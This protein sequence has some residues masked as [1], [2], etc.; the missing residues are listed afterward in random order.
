MGTENHISQHAI[1]CKDCQS[2]IYF[3]TK[4]K[5][6]DFKCA[7]CGNMVH[8]PVLEPEFRYR[9]SSLV[10]DPILQ[11][12]YDAKTLPRYRTKIALLP[13][14]KNVPLAPAPKTKVPTH[15]AQ[16]KK[17]TSFTPTKTSKQIKT[18]TNISQSKYDIKKPSAI[19]NTVYF[20][21]SRLKDD[22][23]LQDLFLRYP[24]L[25]K[26]F[27]DDPSNLDAAKRI[28]KSAFPERMPVNYVLARYELPGNGES[29]R[30]NITIRTTLSLYLKP[31]IDPNCQMSLS[32]FVGTK[33][34]FCVTGIDVVPDNGNT[35]EEKQVRALADAL[36][37][38]L[39]G[40]EAE[41]ARLAGRS[42]A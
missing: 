17:R 31:R 33:S 16:P 24:K 41:L 13:R 39:E 28:I 7:V 42:S 3:I 14:V 4:K 40:Y 11:Y 22:D 6:L 9:G 26:D 19:E 38:N 1:R 21:L 10:Q 5:T 32:G 2:K 30:I 36:R 12:T 37:E 35:E 18:A 29:K 20:D 34:I 25:V 15:T 23:N 27:S 8:S